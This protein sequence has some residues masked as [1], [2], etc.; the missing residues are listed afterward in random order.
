MWLCLNNAFYSVVRDN[1]TEDDLLLRARRATDIEFASTMLENGADRIV[2]TPKND[3]QFRIKITKDEL[4][5]FLAKQVDL[6]DYSNFKNSVV[7]KSLGNMY[8][9]IWGLGVEHLDPHMPYRA[10]GYK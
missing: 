9:R 3:Y 2:H 5:M 7:D 10:W 1:T 6:I 8:N 4:K